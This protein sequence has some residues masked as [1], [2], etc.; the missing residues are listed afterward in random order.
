MILCSNTKQLTFWKSA[1][2]FFLDSAI[3]PEQYV[4]ED[5]LGL[6]ECSVMKKRSTNDQN[7]LSFGSSH[8]IAM[9]HVFE[10]ATTP[11]NKALLTF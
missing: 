5:I 4:L 3:V 2:V 6:Q 11:H 1:Y 10:N 9:H 7:L 8:S